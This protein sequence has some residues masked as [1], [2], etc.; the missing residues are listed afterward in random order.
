MTSALQLVEIDVPYCS[1]TY[2][3]A[4]C[5]AQ[6]SGVSP[7]NV[8]AV[9]FNGE[10]AT[11][12]AGLTGVADSKQVTGSFWFRMLTP[13]LNDYLFSGATAVN[14]ATE[15]GIVIRRFADHISIDCY[16][17]A[18]SK[19][20]NI[21]STPTHLINNWYHCLFSLD[22]NNP[23][24]ARHLYIDDVNSLFANFVNNDTIDFTIA[25]W[26]FGAKADGTA[27][28]DGGFAE[29]WLAPGVYLDFSVAS[30]RRKF[31]TSTLRPMGL[32]ASG[33]IPT[34]TSP[35]V[36]FRSD[37][38]IAN[39]GTGGTFTTKG[40]GVEAIIPF[41]TADVKCFNSL[42]T[43]QDLPNFTGTQTLRFCENVWDTIL[44]HDVTTFPFIQSVDYQPAIVSLEGEIGQRA[45]V[46]VLL[47]DAR[48]SDL[49][50]GFDKYVT[51]RTYNPYDLGTFWGKFRARNPYMRGRALRLYIGEAGQ[52]VAS[53]ETRYFIIDSTSG[54]TREGEFTIT[55]QDMLKL[56]SGDRVLAPRPS[57]GF[58]NA[59][60][61][62]GNQTIAIA[63]PGILSQYPASGFACIGGNEVVSFG[64][65]AGNN[66][67][68]AGRGSF[69][70]T[71]VAHN[72]QD[73][74]QL[75]LNYSA[76]D[77]AD[78]IKD[79]LVTYAG[80]DTALIPIND[81]HTESTTYLSIVISLLITE[82]T[83]VDKLLTEILQATGSALWWDDV[84]RKVRWQ[85]IRS[86][87]ATANRFT[88]DN[89]IADSL[90]VG[91]Q[92]EKRVSQVVVYFG[93]INPT[94]KADEPRNYRST[95]VVTDTQSEALEGSSAI[96]VIYARAIAAGGRTV[97]NRIGTRYLGR[98]ARAPRQFKFELLRFS[99]EEP[100][101]GGGYLL[102]GPGPVYPSWPFQDETGGPKEAPIQLTRVA[103]TPDRW[104]VEAEEMLAT[105]IDDIIVTT[106]H[107][108]IFDSNQNEINLKTSHDSLY[109][110]A[111]SGDTVNCYINGGVFIGANTTATPAFTVG[112]GWAGGVTINVFNNGRIQGCGG[113][114]GRA[115][116]SSGS[117]SA[118]NGFV[119]GKAFFTTQNIALQNNG[120]I[121]GGGGGGGGTYSFPGYT[122]GG[123]GG[124]GTNAG[125]GGSATGGTAGNF[126]G[127]NGSADA[128]GA[129]GGNPAFGLAGGAGGG[130]G[131][132]GSSS[133]NTSFP[134]Q[135]RTGGAAGAAIDG[136]SHITLTGAGS[137][138]GA[139]IN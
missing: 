1:L 61:T 63:P 7:L 10:Y 48:H 100:H 86:I 65:I 32:G 5:Q 75:C 12:G 79:L 92:P 18:L 26:S 57:N 68:I 71:D 114:G 42:G 66:V 69:N 93:Q 58:L 97:A 81:W 96:K 106:N 55:G 38:S 118:E 56:A 110:A 64:T 109:P 82:P 4:P 40:A 95:E 129:G 99:V 3:I 72:A 128:G 131:A 22:C 78:V 73:R 39:N 47:R 29:F 52:A 84:N 43:C 9:Q 137:I 116:A 21:Q 28:W 133:V 59:N 108:I 125:L 34:G 45:S 126:P 8:Q 83:A 136:I 31:I 20:V 74:F 13:G 117:G 132:A 90:E 127:Q 111:V 135:A 103:S 139:Q 33:D 24:T 50:P 36:W 23:T 6:L 107:T 91:D 122:R 15:A 115:T 51:E 113:Q 87:P 14:G 94:I 70:T 124:A 121:Y 77:P 85:V 62:T 16:N 60:I 104:I 30:N 112:T 46:K 35:R 27:K 41:A 11:R 2:S 134:G 19:F 67:N 17:A 101:L 105:A 89:V 44:P 102:G 88:E 123:G 49:G 80:I 54:P 120:Q 37:G 76:M 130:P 138:L 53:L 119:G 25:D 98:Y